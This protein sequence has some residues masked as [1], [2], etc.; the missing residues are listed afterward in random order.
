MFT[1]KN[2]NLFQKGDILQAVRIKDGLLLPS[3][4]SCIIPCDSIMK[5]TEDVSKSYVT[6]TDA[7]GNLCRTSVNGLI[8]GY[9]PSSRVRFFSNKQRLCSTLSIVSMIISL[10]LFI[11]ALV[12]LI[13]TE[14]Y[15]WIAMLIIFG[16]IFIVTGASL[17]TPFA[18]NTYDEYKILTKNTEGENVNE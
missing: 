15:T 6:V 18:L 3:K 1:T 2:E 11:S 9:K 8:K 16:I 5:V 13:T 10:V 17:P 4:E 12:V 7:N 14:N